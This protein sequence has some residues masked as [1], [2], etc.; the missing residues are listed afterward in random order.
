MFSIS[1]LLLCVCVCIWVMKYTK[2]NWVV[3]DSIKE[4]RIVHNVSKRPKNSKINKFSYFIKISTTFLFPKQIHKR[5]LIFLLF[6]KFILIII[7]IIFI[8]LIINV[9]LL[10]F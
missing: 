5:H 2:Y 9:S 10:L 7:I 6:Q 3:V 4:F 1:K 8:W